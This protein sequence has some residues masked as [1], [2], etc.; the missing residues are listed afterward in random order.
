MKMQVTVGPCA[1][2]DTPMKLAMPISHPQP[3]PQ[4]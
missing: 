1:G 3:Q 2:E 4:Q